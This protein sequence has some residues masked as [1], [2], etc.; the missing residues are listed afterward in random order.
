MRFYSASVA[1]LTALSS[2]K[3]ANAQS[4]WNCNEEYTFKP[5]PGKFFV[6]YVSIR[7]SVL[8]QPYISICLPNAEF[9]GFETAHGF[10]CGCTGHARQLSPKQ[11]KLDYYLEVFNGHGCDSTAKDLENGYLEYNGKKVMMND[12]GSDCGP[13]DGGISCQFDLP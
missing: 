2:L 13:R 1:V 9:N 8:L 4:P 5:T 7:D 10:E 11:T 12:G 3:G 6:H